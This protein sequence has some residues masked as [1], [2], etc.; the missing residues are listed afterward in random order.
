MNVVRWRWRQ[1][2]I[3]FHLNAC[4]NHI[5]VCLHSAYYSDWIKPGGKFESIC[6]AGDSILPLLPLLLLLLFL[7]LG[8]AAPNLEQGGP[9]QEAYKYPSTITSM[10]ERGG[11]G[12]GSKGEDTEK[13]YLLLILGLCSSTGFEQY[14]TEIQGRIIE[15]PPFIFFFLTAF[16]LPGSWTK[17]GYCTFSEGSFKRRSQQR[18]QI[19]RTRSDDV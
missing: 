19:S 18:E 17:V 4:N 11:G 7:S 12:A 13:A 14:V 6:W 15:S 5:S 9:E 3:R 8:S 1:P 10:L 2:C 16:V